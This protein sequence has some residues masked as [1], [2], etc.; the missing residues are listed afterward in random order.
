MPLCHQSA[1]RVWNKSWCHIDVLLESWWA[2]TLGLYPDWCHV[3]LGERA[4][5][6]WLW[7]PD[8]N[9]GVTMTSGGNPMAERSRF[10]NPLCWEEK[11]RGKLG[12]FPG[13]PGL[14]VSHGM[15]SFEVFFAAWI[16]NLL[17]W[18]QHNQWN[19]RCDHPCDSTV[20]LPPCARSMFIF[21]STSQSSRCLGST[22]VKIPAKFQSDMCISTLIFSN[23]RLW[24]NLKQ[25]VLPNRETG[26]C[27]N[28]WPA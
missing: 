21:P 26:T 14:R 24:V 20:M 9:D 8:G 16:N 17:I 5:I 11:L 12:S 13:F 25:N 1:V 3:N 23:S 22:A 18:H 19:Q 27:N 2:I 6:Q 15:E 10:I 4:G 28:P 7:Q